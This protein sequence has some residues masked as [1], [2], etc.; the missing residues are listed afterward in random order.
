MME[1][2]FYVGESEHHWNHHPKQAGAYAC[3]APKYGRTKKTL[4]T[5][6]L[7]VASDVEY[8]ILDSGAFSDTIDVRLSFDE[9]LERQIQHAHR[10]QYA[11]R[12]EALASYDLLIDEQ[13]INGIREKKRWEVSPAEYAVRQTVAAAEYLDSKRQ[14]INRAFGHHVGL[15]L[16]AQGVDAEQYLRCAE[17]V[18]NYMQDGDIFG[19]GGWCILGKVPSLLL[20]FYEAMPLVIPMLASKGVKRAHIWGVIYPKAFGPLLYLCDRYGIQLSTDSAGPSWY[21]AMGNWG[22]GSWRNNAYERPPVL[23]SCKVVDEHGHKAPTCEPGTFCRGLERIRHV[24]ETRQW[25]R[26]FRVREEQHYRQITAEEI[27][28]MRAK[29]EKKVKQ[30]KPEPGCQQ[31]ALFEEVA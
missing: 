28:Q 4:A 2:L 10:Y 22:F 11:D 15:V 7:T 9:A 25:L 3:V 26:D 6:S 12:V 21:P 20:P 17:Q 5:S 1:P 29:A 13:A 8:I 31:L 19:L 24:A 30:P 16:S 23:D 27:E 18:V 14:Y